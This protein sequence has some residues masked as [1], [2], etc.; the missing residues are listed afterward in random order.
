MV[1]FT[2]NATSNT[3]AAQYHCHFPVSITEV[4]WLGYCAFLAILQRRPS[5]VQAL[6]SELNRRCKHSKYAHAKEATLGVVQHPAHA[7]LIRSILL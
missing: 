3:L 5:V 4:Q 6:V 1:Y 2:T 7:E